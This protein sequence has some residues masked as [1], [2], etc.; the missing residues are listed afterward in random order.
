MKWLNMNQK[1]ESD[2]N[3]FIGQPS[4]AMNS[5]VDI[6][7]SKFGS[8]MDRISRYEIFPDFSVKLVFRFSL[9]KPSRMVLI[10]PITE[11]STI[12]T[13]ESS[14]Y[15]G[16]RFQPG[17]IPDLKS[18]RVTDIIDS[19]AEIQE[20]CGRSVPELG[21][22]MARKTTHCERQN[23]MEDL[24]V[25]FPPR[26]GDPIATKAMRLIRQSIA[27][28]RIS[29]ILRHVGA[30]RRCLERHVTGDMGLTPKKIQRLIRLRRV[31]NALY[32]REF[33][34]LS[35]LALDLGYTDQSHMT[36]DVK[37]LTGH[38]PGERSL[39]EPRPISEYSHTRRVYRYK[40]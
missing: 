29:D 11:V 26:S 10:G 4:L 38:S 37:A 3:L 12:E 19:Y 1:T 36:R 25:H 7:W 15:F 9:R 24:L 23:L 14:D 6:Y 17:W 21:I 8:G 16:V 39:L 27:R 32:E 40:A 31:L 20:F 33:E 35:G 5:K 2:M 18:Y 22:E 28:Q 13:D 34:T 30:R